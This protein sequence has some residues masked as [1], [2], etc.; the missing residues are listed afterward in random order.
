VVRASKRQS[1]LFDARC[2]DR[3]PRRTQCEINDLIF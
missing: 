2:I 3:D 1:D